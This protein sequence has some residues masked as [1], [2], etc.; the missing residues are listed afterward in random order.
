MNKSFG[1]FIPKKKKNSF[2]KTSLRW[3][4]ASCD[5][6]LPHER[7]AVDPRARYTLIQLRVDACVATGF[8]EAARELRPHNACVAT[9]LLPTTRLFDGTGN[10][11]Y[12]LNNRKFPLCHSRFRVFCSMIVI[13]RYRPNSGE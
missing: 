2:L 6:H 9:Y 10:G 4:S 12:E 11:S 8:P 13:D 3:G 1:I 7:D 5:I